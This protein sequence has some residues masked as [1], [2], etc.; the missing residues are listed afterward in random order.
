MNNPQN[1]LAQYREILDRARVRLGAVACSIALL[2]GDDL[3]YVAAVGPGADVLVGT[4]MPVEQGIAGWVAQ[5]E[6]AIVVAEAGADARFARDVAELTGYIPHSLLVVPVFGAGGLTAVL[7]V[8]DR[9][10]NRPESMSD[11]DIAAAFAEEL[12]GTRPAWSSA[13]DPVPS[14]L[15]GQLPLD[16]EWA[17]GAGSGDGVRVAIID[18]GIDFTH[19]DVAGPGV[20]GATVSWDA[21][22]GLRVTAALHDDL[23]GHG[24]A[25]AGVI[26]RVAPAAELQSVRVLGSRLSA[27]GEVF[28]A[29]LRWAID[30]GARV[31]NLSLS[32]ANEAMRASLHELADVAAHSGVV[33]VCAMNNASV[34]CYPSSFSNVISVAS[35]RDN[36]EW[37]AWPLLANPQP[38]ADFAAPGIDVDV[39]WSGGRR[40]R[41]SGNSFAAPFVSGLVARMLSAHP[42]LTS[43]Q[44]KAVLRS[45]AANVAV[46]A[47]VSS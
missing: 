27:R 12:A 7:T 19:P 37:G 36:A 22:T 23:V 15:A 34:P 44:V 13:F 43:Y 42:Q 8:L 14:V 1:S 18:S 16:A 31:V 5:T 17:F 32:S 28:A 38:P 47:K 20:N 2:D 10:E 33:L 29:G 6:Q 41:A 30:S 25:C 24:T 46:A 4:R 21:D 39:A 45:V 9:D 40:V 3:S 11:V 35:C 26:R